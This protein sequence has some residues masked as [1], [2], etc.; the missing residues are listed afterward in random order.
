MY[1]RYFGLNEEP[2]SIAPNPHYLFMSEQHREALAHLMYGVGVGGGF[3]MLTGEVGTGKTTV[4]RCLLEQLP[5]NTDIAFIL[6]PLQQPIELLGTVCDEL[7]IDYDKTHPSLRG[8]TLNLYRFLIQNHASGRNTVLLIDEAQNLE[9]KMLELIRL[10]TN[11]E[12][13]TKKLLQIVF[14]GQPELKERLQQPQLRQL[15]QRITARYHLLPLSQEETQAYIRHRLQVAGLPAGQELFP[16]ALVKEV[17]AHSGGIPRLINVLCDRMLLGT[18]AQNR[19]AVDKATLTKS[20]EEVMGIDKRARVFPWRWPALAASAGLITLVMLTVWLWP[21]ST[22]E[23]K[24][25]SVPPAVLQQIAANMENTGPA[26]PFRKAT[27]SSQV[28]ALNALLLQ[29]DLIDAPEPDPCAAIAAEGWRC[30]QYSLRSWRDLRQIDRPGILTLQLPEAQPQYAALIKLQDNKAHLSHGDTSEEFALMNLGEHWDGEFTFI[31]QAPESYT[32][33]IARG[34]KAELVGW[35]AAK[36][37]ELDG[38]DQSLA[39][40]EFNRPLRERLKLF[41]REHQLTVDGI[42]GVRTLLK[43]NEALGLAHTLE[44]RP[45]AATN[46]EEG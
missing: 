29:L 17:Y 11:L 23:S 1:S 42:A 25:T 3:V 38:Q 31:W 44:P 20:V 26:E 19:T 13:N 7:G 8:L 35:L 6:N 39:T 5:E 22:P 14:I 33:P 40:Q 18:Y 21:L 45:A 24:A 10:L 28:Q 9:D 15:A 30:E 12:T 43:L 4:S 46:S 41:Q 34:D 16:P 32:K 37:A 27:H 36:L 2:F